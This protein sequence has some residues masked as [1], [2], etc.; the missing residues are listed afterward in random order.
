M[1]P[2]RPMNVDLC[3]SNGPRRGCV[4]SCARNIALLLMRLLFLSQIEHFI[5][6]FMF[7]Q[8]IIDCSSNYFLKNLS[9]S[10]LFAKIKQSVQ[11]IFFFFFFTIRALFAVQ[12]HM[13][14]KQFIHTLIINKFR[15][16]NIFTC[17]CGPHTKFERICV[18]CVKVCVDLTLNV[19]EFVR[20]CVKVFVV[21]RQ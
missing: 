11:F 13:I 2:D 21:A 9:S 4:Q 7:G 1:C 8:A 14:T 20:L 18:F 15:T 16:T 6:R 19:R 12:S 17:V 5:L 3:V 10:M